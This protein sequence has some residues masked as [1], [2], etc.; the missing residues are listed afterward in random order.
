MQ[1]PPNLYR[2]LSCC[3]V[4]RGGAILK[5]GEG[6]K[7]PP[8]PFS[9]SS[10]VAEVPPSLL[11][12]PK[13]AKGGGGG[14]V[15]RPS[16]AC[17]SLAELGIGEKVGGGSL[18]PPHSNEGTEAQRNFEEEN[19]RGLLLLGG[20]WKGENDV[21]M[22]SFM[23]NTYLQFLQAFFIISLVIHPFSPHRCGRK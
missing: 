14:G 3:G 1:R 23:K 5:G 19:L 11:S 8:S 22:S 12:S 10:E 17:R 4:E 13:A 20:L 21:P 15:K 7:G 6:R 2:G 16:A 18:P 9:P